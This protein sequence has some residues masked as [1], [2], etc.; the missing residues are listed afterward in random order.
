MVVNACTTSLYN[1]PKTKRVY[2]SDT[3]KAYIQG[4]AVCRCG[5]KLSD[6]PYVDN[7]DIQAWELG[8]CEA[9]PERE[10][11]EVTTD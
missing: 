11:N 6:N 7:R 4:Y 2:M 5:K 8:Y 9:E 3:R 1:L 10:K